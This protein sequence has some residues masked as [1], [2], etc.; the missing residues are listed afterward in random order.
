MDGLFR[1]DLEDDR[2]RSPGH[3]FD[4][5][6]ADETKENVFARL[7]IA[8][9]HWG[10]TLQ[11]TGGLLVNKKSHWWLIYF[12]WKGNQWDYGK[13]PAGAAITVPTKE[14]LEKEIKRC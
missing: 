12:V 1:H 2:V 10:Q 7:Q 8:V 6:T 5:E 14:G 3:Y 13:R 11:H 4:T 9:S